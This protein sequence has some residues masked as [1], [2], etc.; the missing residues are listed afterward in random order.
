MTGIVIPNNGTIGSASDT[1]AISIA[2]NGQVTFSS[3]TLATQSEV[4]GTQ[5]TGSITSGNTAL[6]VASGS[7]ISNGDFV[8]GEGIAQGTTVLS[9]GGTTSLTLS[10][11]AN[12]TLSSNKI[13]FYSASKLLSPGLVGGMLCRAWCLINGS[14]DI[15]IAFNISSVSDDGA[16]KTTF[17][18]QT[19]M[20][21]DEYI[22][23]G[24]LGSDSASQY[25]GYTGYQTKV[26]QYVT[27][28]TANTSGSLFDS[29]E[30][31]IAVFSR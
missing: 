6:T 5:T 19:N 24:M 21:D 22:V 16:G 4:F 1:D 18:F 27:I 3:N 9:G 7:G 26:K 2:S 25:F 23:L 31:Q 29:D 8:V 12:A 13:A 15:H 17:N 20:V 11:N 30:V 14:K 10:A 28:N